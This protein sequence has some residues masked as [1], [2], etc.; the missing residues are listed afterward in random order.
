MNRLKKKPLLIIDE[1]TGDIFGRT[2][3]VLLDSGRDS[4]FRVQDIWLASQAIQHNLKFLHKESKG[5][6]GYTRSGSSNFQATV[7]LMSACTLA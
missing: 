7:I 2:A 1:N 4:S 6:H 5:L 3:A